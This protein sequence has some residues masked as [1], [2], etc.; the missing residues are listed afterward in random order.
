MIS[1]TVPMAIGTKYQVRYLDRRKTWPA[2][3]MVNRAI[4]II[5]RT[6]DGI[7]LSRSVL[8]MCS[9]QPVTRMLK[10]THI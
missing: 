2:K 3:P 1:I 6:R 4:A 5:D 10:L 8:A 9:M 7:Y